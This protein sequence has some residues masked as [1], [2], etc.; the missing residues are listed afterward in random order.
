CAV[1]HVQRDLAFELQGAI[2]HDARSDDDPLAAGA[3]ADRHPVGAGLVD[4]Q[5]SAHVRAGADGHV[6]AAG[7][8]VAGHDRRDQADGTVDGLDVALDLAAASD[9]HTAV[10]G[11]HAA[12]DA[13]AFARV[14]AAVD[15]RQSAARDVVAGADGA[16]HRAGVAA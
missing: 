3:D 6:A 15:R 14:D 9:E 11:F 12:A 4:V 2:D 7:A 16:V 13:R 1:V 10:D 5:A 8:D